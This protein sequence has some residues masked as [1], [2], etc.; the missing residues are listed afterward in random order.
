MSGTDINTQ[1]MY[2]ALMPNS[3]AIVIDNVK[4]SETASIDDLDFGVFRVVGGKAQRIEYRIKNPIE[5]GLNAYALS[6]TA[7]VPNK[8]RTLIRESH[9]I[10]TMNSTKLAKL[11][12]NLE[13][14][15]EILDPV[16]VQSLELWLEL[17]ESIDNNVVKEVPVDVKTLMSALDA[18]VKEI[19]Y[20]LKEIKAQAY[21]KQTQR[22]L[23]FIIFGVFL[24]L[25][26][27]YNLT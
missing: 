13:T 18:S 22:T 3:V 16:D 19:G 27:F 9:F 10:P 26:A 1:R 2:Q 7:Y 6:D 24:E 21:N 11:K 17:A 4:Y 5:F 14:H 12:A 23:L 20:E 8:S 15:K 25:F